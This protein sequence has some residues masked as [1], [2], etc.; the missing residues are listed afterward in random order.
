MVIEWA[1]NR[2]ASWMKEIEP[3][4]TAS[5][6][7]LE[8]GLKIIYNA[9]A[10][11]TISLIISALTSTLKEMILVLIAFPV[12]RMFSG[13][14]HIKSSDM[15]VIT[16]I[17][18]MCIISI[19][20]SFIEYLDMNYMI[21]SIITILLLI[22]Y[23]PSGINHNMKISNKTLKIMAISIVVLDILIIRSPITMSTYFVQSLTLINL[24]WKEEYKL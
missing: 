11:L 1:A 24:N 12:L 5:K 22:K 8:Y 10:I 23:S 14:I 21:I 19:G 16:S 15:C 7:V 20:S 18:I 2:T 6:E 3:E 13:G 4:R 9:L 17:T